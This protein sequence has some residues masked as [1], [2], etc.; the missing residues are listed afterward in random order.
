MPWGCDRRGDQHPGVE[1]DAHRSVAGAHR[2][3]LVVGEL[4]R[5]IIGQL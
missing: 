5:L 2:V 1:H 3:K 4:Q